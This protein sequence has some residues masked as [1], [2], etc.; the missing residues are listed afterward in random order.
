MREQDM[1]EDYKQKML[2]YH[3]V[4]KM[5]ETKYISKFKSSCSTVL[6]LMRIFIQA[7][8]DNKAITNDE[9]TEYENIRSK[10]RFLSD[11]AE[12]TNPYN[13]QERTGRGRNNTPE[14]KIAREQKYEQ[15]IGMI[16]PETGKCACVRDP[17]KMK[18]FAERGYEIIGEFDTCEEFEAEEAANEETD[19]YLSMFGII[20]LSGTIYD[21][22]GQE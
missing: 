5:R 11:K 3:Y 18:H 4:D 9:I 13:I 17:G 14:D 22:R 19:G 20:T 8:V 21:V 10:I 16:D 7:L 1:E 12:I 15:F 6:D 2:L